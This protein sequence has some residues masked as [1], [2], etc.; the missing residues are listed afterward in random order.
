MYAKEPAQLVLRLSR[1]PYKRYIRHHNLSRCGRTCSIL[2]PPP[3]PN[4][5]WKRHNL[6]NTL[7]NR[8][9]KWRLDPTWGQD[10]HPPAQSRTGRMGQSGAVLAAVNSKLDGN[11][12]AAI[13][14]LCEEGQPAT[15][16]EP[17]L[18]LLQDKHPQDS[19]PEALEDLPDP[20]STVAWQ[21]S[22]GVPRQFFYGHFV[23]DTSSTDISSTDIPS[24]T[25]YQRVGHLY[26]QL[27]FQQ[28]IIFINS[29]FYLHYD[30]FLS[31]PLSLT[32]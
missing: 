11:I 4:H 32:L 24:T 15:P 16:T 17:N 3:L 10:E 23:Y 1:P 14:I 30:S 22:V 27:L 26:I 9:D 29:N 5:G 13:R 7:K 21:A 12:K 2:H 20:A 6:T 8:T 31:I 28:I 19:C 18:K 25:V